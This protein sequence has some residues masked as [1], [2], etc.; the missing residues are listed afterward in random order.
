[1]KKI[2]KCVKKKKQRKIERLDLGVGYVC[3]RG[4]P[5]PPQQS[6]RWGGPHGRE[7]KKIISCVTYGWLD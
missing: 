6:L 5:T 3:F 7:K 4:G 1:M 2:K